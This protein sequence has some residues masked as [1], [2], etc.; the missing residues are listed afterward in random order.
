MK[1]Q[2]NKVIVVGIIILLIGI[3]IVPRTSASLDDDIE[4]YI[5][6]GL[7]N[8]LK[9]PMK[10]TFGFGMCVYVVNNR[11]ES[12]KIYI[13]ED[14]YTLLG[15]PLNVFQ[16]RW[17]F[18]MPSNYSYP[19]WSSGGVPFPCRYTVTVQAGVIKYVSRS[20]FAFLRIVFFP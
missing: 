7:N 17:S 18:V 4:I 6:A 5:S 11:S 3:S 13:Q 12:I 2:L 19:T 20:G 10:S 9:D 15:E 1:N 16:Q 8:Y 14:Y